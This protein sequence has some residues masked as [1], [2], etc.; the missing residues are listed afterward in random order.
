[1]QKSVEEDR[2]LYI[3]GSDIPIIMGISP[4]KSYYQLLKEKVGIEEPVKVDNEYV[5]YGNIMEEKI[6]N[7][8]NEYRES[9]FIEHKKIN[10]DIRCHVDGWN[11]DN[12]SILEIKTT[13]RI[14]KKIR[15]YKYYVVQLLFYM[16]N[17]NAKKGILAIYQRP[18]D[19]DEEFNKDLLTTYEIDI[20]DFMDWVEEIEEAVDKYRIDKKRLEDNILLGEED[21]K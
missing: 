1:M 9:N 13:S 2:N 6:R 21:F 11:E 14:H 3:G 15:T 19:F 16:I 8:I 20:N 10:N 7:Y 17:Y 4:F 5:D 12:N 18:K